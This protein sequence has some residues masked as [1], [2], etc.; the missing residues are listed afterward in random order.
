MLPCLNVVPPSFLMT[1][2]VTT[3]NKWMVT[4]H[5]CNQISTNLNHIALLVLKVSFF[6]S[7]RWLLDIFSPLGNLFMYAGISAYVCI[8][9]CMSE[10]VLAAL[11]K[12]NYT[13]LRPQCAF[14]VLYEYI[15]IDIS[16]RL[17]KVY[18]LL[19][20]TKKSHGFHVSPA[21]HST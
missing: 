8:L 19:K 17:D 9:V 4:H 10:F 7:W 14:Y 11:R 21:P 20:Q 12:P 3:T 5:W 16:C 13:A 1:D 18:F 2:T 15:D 6:T